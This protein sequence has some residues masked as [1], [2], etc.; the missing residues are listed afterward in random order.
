MPRHLGQAPAAQ[1]CVCRHTGRIVGV[2]GLYKD[3]TD[4]GKSCHALTHACT[5]A[6]THTHTHTYTQRRLDGLAGPPAKAI[7]RPRLEPKLVERL[8]G[9]HSGP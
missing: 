8:A 5:H 3:P 2:F 1:V 4:S 6:H 7:P 9:L